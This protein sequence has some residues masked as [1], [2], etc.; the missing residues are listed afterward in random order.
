[1][2]AAR[3]R[4][5]H[6]DQVGGFDLL[7]G[8]G[9]ATSTKDCRQTD[10]RGSVSSSIAGV[11]VVRPHDLASEPLSGIVHLVGRLRTAEHA[12]GRFGI[13]LRFTKAL[14]NALERFIPAGFDQFAVLADE[15]RGES[16]SWHGLP[17]VKSA[18][19]AVQP[20]HDVGPVTRRLE[21]LTYYTQ[22][23]SLGAQAR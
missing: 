12:E 4:S 22:H 13:R 10:D 9:A 14:D 20:F 17:L 7:V 19:V 6:D 1:V 8:D 15:R 21:A 23:R 2:R 16:C 11:D 3:V 18:K 5:P